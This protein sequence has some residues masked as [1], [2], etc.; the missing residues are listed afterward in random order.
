MAVFCLRWWA[1]RQGCSVCFSDR[2]CL[3]CLHLS[4]LPSQSTQIQLPT[5]AAWKSNL[6]VFSFILESYKLSCS[7]SWRT[8]VL[9][10]VLLHVMPASQTGNPSNMNSPNY[11]LKNIFLAISLISCWVL[12]NYITECC[13]WLS[14][15]RSII[16]TAVAEYIWRPT[17]WN[18]KSTTS[19]QK[20]AFSNYLNPLIT[21]TFILN[22][23]VF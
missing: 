9:Q 21:E 14:L 18:N 10:L 2:L 12:C 1:G 5:M 3:R 22:E 17:E 13:M 4:V 6:G 11:F 23:K 19:R 7:R 15:T 20:F 8:G 16:N